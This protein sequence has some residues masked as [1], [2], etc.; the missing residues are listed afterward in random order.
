[1]GAAGVPA[2]GGTILIVDDDSGNI[3]VL[4]DLLES[5]Y[6]VVFATSGAQAL[7]LVH[8]SAPDLVLLDVMM[9]G[10]DGYELCAHLKGDGETA[11]IPVIFIT[12]LDDAAAE[13]RGLELGA[14]DYVTKPFSPAI[15]RMRVRNHMELK[16]S[17][18]AITQLAITD[19]LTG[20]ANRRRFDETLDLEYRRHSRSGGW[21]S[22]ILLDIDHFK[23]FNDTYG[24]VAG[25]DCLRNVAGAV[26]AARRTSD[27]AARYGGEEFACILPETH[28]RGAMTVAQAIQSGIRALAI[29]HGASSTT[30][31]VTA[32]L[33]VVSTLCSPAMTS[34]DVVTAA[35]AA[36][37]RAK[38]EGRDR[39]VVGEMKPSL[40]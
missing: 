1:M 15:V 8:R 37:Y 36:L 20:L 3:E 39:I 28:E 32:S 4:A 6:E 2:S 27:L 18:D 24:H 40:A 19:G 30:N 26:G 16:R 34:L 22:L 31:R 12:G 13:T 35:D 38:A 33:G 9:P 29:P 11:D 5:E 10:M 17:R 7:E 14:V 23:A 25:D 21:F